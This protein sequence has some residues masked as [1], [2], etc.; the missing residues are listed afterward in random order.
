MIG[1]SIRTLLEF[2]QLI[3]EDKTAGIISIVIAGPFYVWWCVESYRLRKINIKYASQVRALKEVSKKEPQPKR[4]RTA[5]AFK[6]IF[7]LIKQTANNS[8]GFERGASRTGIVLGILFSSFTLIAGIY[9]AFAIYPYTFGTIFFRIFF[10][11]TPL[12]LLI[13]II[14]ILLAKAITWIVIGFKKT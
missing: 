1:G 6:K 13:F 5:N 4:L 8:T 3:K 12:S 2:S 7:H 9:I 11:V 14:P 10:I